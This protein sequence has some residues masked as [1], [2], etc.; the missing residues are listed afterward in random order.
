[1]ATATDTPPRSPI[2]TRWAT[3]R[4]TVASE[5]EVLAHP[6]T[7]LGFVKQQRQQP[8]LKFLAELRDPGEQRRLGCLF[9]SEV[10]QLP[11]ARAVVENRQE[12]VLGVECSYAGVEGAAIDERVGEPVKRRCRH[13]LI[14]VGEHGAGGLPVALKDREKPAG[15]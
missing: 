5:N 13:A 4:R 2:S 14:E 1:L 15:E 9:D 6:A 3:P 8:R 12:F 7:E 11:P 10:A